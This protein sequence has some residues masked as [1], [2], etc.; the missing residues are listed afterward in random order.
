MRLNSRLASL[1]RQVLSYPPELDVLVAIFALAAASLTF[2]KLLSE[3]RE[4][5][6]H[7]AD[8]VILLALRKPN[9]LSN[10]IGPQWLETVCR[11]L[12]SLGSPIVLALITIFVVCYLC[13]DGKRAIAV[14]VSVAIAGGA[15]FSTLLKLGFARPRPELVSHL[16]SV[17]SF[18][19]P[20]SHATMATVTY[21]TLG[22]LLARVQKRR[23]MKFYLI[24]VALIL[25]I[26]VGL[27]RIFLGVHWPTDVIA[28]WCIGTAW[29]L[30]CWLVAT[31]LQYRGTLERENASTEPER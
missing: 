18:S 16:V 26:L 25:A 23:R 2:L 14:F 24:S 6:T 31:W 5:E 12:T 9:D 3:M 11:D 8:Q 10:P 4:G 17:D 29:A 20:S 7:G 1:W 30:G 22:V 13:I 28:G 27:T 21:L 15:I 19:F